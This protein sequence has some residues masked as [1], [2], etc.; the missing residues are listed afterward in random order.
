MKRLMKGWKKLGNRGL[1][2][3]EL[4]C[5]IAILSLVGTTVGGILIVSAQSYD[6]G[7]NEV[8][9]QQEAQ[10]VV[11]QINDLIID[12][13]ATESVSFADNTLVIPEG[14]KTH[15]VKYDAATKQLLYSC[16]GGS[17]SGEE[18]MA[19]G[20][21]AFSADTASF[22]DSGNLYLDIG[23]ERESAGG[24]KT[25]NATFQIT[26]RNGVVD[27]TPSAS[28]DVIDDVVLEPNQSYTFNPDVVGISNKAVEWDIVG[29][30]TDSTTHMLGN[31]IYIGSA[32][33]GS[34][35]HLLV[36]TAT[37]DA[38]GNAMAM[39]AVRVRIRRVN[40]VTVKKL[41]VTGTEYKKDAEYLLQADLSGS[42]LDKEPREWDDDYV[43]PYGITWTV[44][45]NGT[46]IPGMTAVAW[47]P[48]NP[49]KAFI[50]VKLN[51]DMPR[52]S[53]ITIKAVA[54][55]PMGTFAGSNSNKTGIS[56]GNVFGEYKIDNSRYF[57]PEHGLA[58][59]SDDPIG[60]FAIDDLKS[61]LISKFGNGNY[62]LVR[63]YRYRETG[64]GDTGWCRWFTDQD[65]GFGFDAGT[66]VNMRPKF[67][68]MMR[69]GIVYDMQVKMCMVNQDTGAVVWP[70]VDTPEDQYLIQGTMDRV[71]ISFTSTDLGFAEELGLP[72]DK[73]AK[74]SKYYNGT[75]FSV[76][77]I[78]SLGGTTNKGNFRNDIQYILEKK[79]GSDWKF[80]RNLQS[81]G[82]CRLEL[83]NYG[84][85]AGEY[86]IKIWMYERHVKY[87][88]DGS[89]TEISNN[90]SYKYEI[91]KNGGGEGY[92]YFTAT[93]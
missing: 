92:F 27:T 77:D 26:A 52:N 72:A 19:N 14:T 42:Y 22:K 36:K 88:D 82:D 17:L 37:K 5:A 13:T 49:A 41:S 8:E 66:S 67:G 40:T 2:L 60:S 25:F 32:E 18:L 87:N 45:A 7:M 64:S 4:I 86:R 80:V 54:T 74:I 63:S 20:I 48:L 91:W 56:Y 10:M 38:E 75:L 68:Y 83:A 30:N 23:L 51:E 84:T 12:T 81:G 70:F 9:L 6:N 16:E 31:T 21:T 78:Y 62:Q 15:K 24:L 71:C 73:N 55:H 43:N 50:K 76:K 33:E 79:E 11:N 29:G 61:L 93:D 44:E 58:R 90:E 46:A 85:G 3:V 89:M 34:I 39:R 53:F 59:G 57:T 65:L 1:T 35:V 28:I 69:Y 47:D